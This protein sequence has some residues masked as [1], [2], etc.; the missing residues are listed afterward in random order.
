MKRRM[1]SLLLIAVMVLGM[2]PTVAMAVPAES[3]GVYQ[4]GTAEDLL[5]FAQQVNGGNTGISAVLTAD[6]NLSGVYNWPGIGISSSKFAGSFDGQN[7]TVTFKDSA[8]GLFGYINGSQNAV[9]TVQNVVIAGSVKTS[10]FAQ[11]AGFVHF[12]GCINRATINNSGS[13]VAGLVGV[14]IGV[15]EAGILKSDV[16]FTNCGNE[17]SVSAGGGNVGGILGYSMT[18]TRLDG[19]YNTG[20]IHGSYNIGGL[21][22][23]LQQANGTCEIKNSYNTGTVTGTSEVGGILGNMYNGVSVVNCYNAGAATYAIAG[24]R[25]NNTATITNSYYLGTKSAKVSPDYNQ[26]QNYNELTNEISTRAVA[27]SAAEMAS[28]EFVQLLGSAFQQSCPTPVLTWQTATAHTGAVCENCALGSTEKEIYDV[29]FQSHDGYTLTG[30]D[31]A[32]QGGSYSFTIAISEGYEK[33]TDF[34]VKVNGEA[35][36]AASNGQYTVLSVDGPLSV[37]VLGV[38]VIPGSHAIQLPGEGYGYRTEGAKTVERDEDYSFTLTFVDGFK[39]GSDF[40]VIA[41][42][43]LSQDLL[44]KGYIPEEVELTGKNGTYTI[45]TVQKDYRIL[46]SGVEAVSKGVT[47]TVNLSITEGHNEFHVDPKNENLMLDKTFT[48]PYFDLSLYGL[49]RYYYNPYCY[50]D[51]NGNLRGIQQVGT[52]ESAYDNITIM[53]AFIVATELYYYGYDQAEVGQ[54]RSYKADPDAFEDAISWS[55]GA[56]SSFMNFWDFGTNLNYYLNYVYPLGYPGWGSTSDQILI[57]DGDVLSIHMITGNASGSRFGFFVVNDTDKK[58]TTSDVIDTYEVDQGEKL[59]LTLYWTS[60]TADYSTGYERIAGKE[61]YWIEAGDQE[62]DVREWNRTDFG[63]TTAAKLV[64]DSNGNVTISTVGLEPGTYYLAALGGWTEGGAVDNAGFQS[65]GGETGPALFKLTVNEYE[66]KLGDVN[67]DTTIDAGDASEILK[68]YAGLTT[69]INAG[70]ADVNGDNTVD[71]GD[72]SEI[73]KYY[74]GLITGFA[75]A[76]Q[77]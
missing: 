72:A 70:I 53:H 17:A 71:A 65:A 12:T 46:V 37:T 43:I 20:N 19:C 28:A 76:N 38:Q 42:Q 9:A 59:N 24:K 49:E 62:A 54:G 5:W 8:V 2:L 64:T 63:N 14:V 3:S 25:Y 34:A 44:D 45:P 22:G 47:A 1:L 18:N 51:E 30:A 56:G 11:S 27:K 75:A 33:A 68:Y 15:T 61:L 31:K 50:V 23:Y 35:V 7:H 55:Q 36:T 57:Q 13:Y 77:N 6:V 41:Q 32:T 29:S 4:I 16:K 21:V 52:P 58:Y 67:G 40:K 48:V 39:A 66:G 73:L 74:A 69:S 10:G 60:T 26:T